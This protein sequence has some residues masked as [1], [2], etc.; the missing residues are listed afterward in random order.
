MKNKKL[1]INI[2]KLL[3]TFLIFELSDIFVLIPVK[4]FNLDINNLSTTVNYILTTFRYICLIFILFLL[5]RKD[6]KVEWKTFKTKITQN[7]DTAVKYYL[8]GLVS[9][10]FF[11]I[12]INFVLQLGGPQNEKAVQ[13]MISSSPLLMLICAGFLAPITEE[14][15]F[16]KAFKNVFTNKWVFVIISGLV[17]GAMHVVNYTFQNPLEVL[18]ILP[19]GSLGACFAYMD[20]KVDSVF[21]SIAM[22]MIHNTA[23]TILSILI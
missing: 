9:M 12:I 16:R 1:L 19:Y 2:V 13:N 23:L 21:P 22:H 17:F 5:Y 20:Y 11:N 4:I 18:Y 8:I 3:I 7:M 15:I 6:L 14:L 10:M